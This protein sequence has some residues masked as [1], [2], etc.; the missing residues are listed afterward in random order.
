MNWKI[1][2]VGLGLMGASLAGALRGWR[3][4]R[5]AGVDVVPETRRKAKSLG[6]VDEAYAEAHDAV[7]GADLTIFCVYAHHIPDIITKSA[8]AFRH[9]SLLTDICGVKSGL[10]SKLSGVLPENL[11]Y[12]GIH[13]MAGKERN[14][15]DNADPAIYKNSGFIICPLSASRRENIDAMREM[16]EYMGAARIAVCPPDEHDSII[17][18]TSDLMHIA[19]AGL[20]IDCHPGVTS[21]FTAGAFRD[22]TRV[23][24]IDAEAWTEL[25]M[26]NR[27]FTLGRLD[28]YIDSLTQMRAALAEGD[29]PK[30]RDLLK[31]AGENKR[32]MLK[33]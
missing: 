32:E 20:C 25:L 6:V 5:I 3:G 9:G 33:R 31:R 11:D 13:P 30:L 23:A 14:G 21:A 10:Y 22:C 7:Q 19:S 2:I 29:E 28:G 16:A 24:D 4:A 17:A 26:D 18:Y 1:C 8:S 12:I 15:F 27:A